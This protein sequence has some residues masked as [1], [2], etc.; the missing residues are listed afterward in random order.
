M[1]RS[2][3][4]RGATVAILAAVLA[5]AC[6]PRG[7]VASP[8]A[9][10]TTAAVGSAAPDQSGGAVQPSAAGPEL[11]G[12]LDVWTIPQGDDEKAI[13]AYGKAFEAAHPGV[14]VKILVVG[15]EAFVTKVNTALQAKAPP[16]I[17]VAEDRT[18]MEAGKVVELTDKFEEWGVDVTDFN[19]G[20]VG[21][22]TPK[23]T[24]ASGVYAVGDYLGGNVLVYNKKLFDAAGVSYPAA[25]TSLTIAQYAD[26]CRKL[27][28]PDP[29]LNK[30]VFGCS[31]PEWGLPIQAKDPFGPDGRTTVGNMDSPEMVAG[32]DLAAGLLRDR[33]APTG[34]I[35]DAASESDLFAAGRLAITWTDFTEVSKYLANGIDFGI[36]PFFVLHEGESFVDTYTAPWATFTDSRDQAL[37]LEF[38][39]FLATDA[40]RLRTEVSADPPLSERVAEEIGYGNDDPIKAEYLT[41]LSAAAKPQVFV[42]PGVE[43]FDPAEVLRLL[44]E[45]GRTDTQ[46]ILHDQAVRSQKELD[47]VW[48]RWDKLG[49]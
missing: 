3:T 19:A 38:L 37:A 36:A 22:T 39:R 30:T 31:M 40:Q 16:D 34:Q 21:R 18:W 14:E 29:D 49:G 27:A 2:A 11:S 6:G 4:I 20:A 12:T 24:L 45:E 41:V 15:E 7:G 44:V 42:P 9:G 1:S 35:L 26:I 33:L 32:F 10:P 23:G 17:A 46:A 25:D 28:R 48:T 5:T 13:K 47:D 43:A 8:P